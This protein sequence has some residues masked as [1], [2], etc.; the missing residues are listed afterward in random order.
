MIPTRGCSIID[1]VRKK[2]MHR[3]YNLCMSFLRSYFSKDCEQPE[4]IPIGRYKLQTDPADRL[5][6]YQPGRY[7]LAMPT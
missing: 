6:I 1:N 3:L 5:R 2:D 7:R 4:G